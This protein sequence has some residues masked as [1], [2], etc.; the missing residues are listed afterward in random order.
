MPK[1]TAAANIPPNHRR[2]LQKSPHLRETWEKPSFCVIVAPD[3]AGRNEA[4]PRKTCNRKG[5]DMH[6]A[7]LEQMVSRLNFDLS[8]ARAEQISDRP[9]RLQLGF[10]APNAATRGRFFVVI[11]FRPSHLDVYVTDHPQ[12]APAVPRSFT[13]LLRKYLLS[14]TVC[15]IRI[16]QGDRLVF[17]EFGS[18][19][20]ARH[21][22]IA[23]LTGRS[24]NLFLIDAQTQKILGKIGKSDD[25][26]VNDIYARPPAGEPMRGENRFAEIPPESYYA[27]VEA[28]IDARAAKESF[29]TAKTEA[30]RRAKKHQTRLNKR[31]ECISGDLKK[32]ETAQIR[33]RE[34]DL[35][36]AYASQIR[37]GDASATVF[38]FETGDPVVIRLDPSISVRENIEKRYAQAKRMKKAEPIIRARFEETQSKLNQINAISAKLE[39][40]STVG[41][42]DEILPMLDMFCIE[43]AAAAPEPAAQGQNR[44]KKAKHKPFKT[45]RA[46]DGTPILVG[47]SAKDNIELTF[48]YARG[49]DVWLHACGAAGSHVVAKAVNPSPETILDAA[50]LAMHYSAFARSSGAEI[51]ITQAKYLKKIKTGAAGKVEVHNEKTM[52][53]R[54]DSARLGRLLAT[55]ES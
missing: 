35:L 50:L 49:N 38:G 12:K 18:S 2:N 25:R 21:A 43:N 3:R 51:Q 22:L 16:A 11:D 28:A 40:A 29:E 34:A 6:Y 10:N 42:I 20:A 15:G 33:R 9:D 23:E 30:L 7:E 13:M 17:F 24:P 55:Q 44:G 45:F 14:E 26:Q 32:A 41:E 8:G 19:G 4:M 27:G 37:Q 5:N 52:Y 48:R 31:Y 47:K 53:V 54:A 1:Y 39:S 46:A 36:N